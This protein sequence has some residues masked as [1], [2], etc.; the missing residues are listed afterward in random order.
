[1]LDDLARSRTR[2]T[3]NFLDQQSAF[4]VDVFNEWDIYKKL[5]AAA[6]QKLTRAQQIYQECIGNNPNATNCT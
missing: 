5:R 2:V 4:N 1:M 6:L 3:K